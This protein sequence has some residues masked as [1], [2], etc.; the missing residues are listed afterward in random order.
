MWE[1]IVTFKCVLMFWPTMGVI[2]SL[3]A[4]L[5]I[6]NEQKAKYE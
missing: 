1:I 5:A 6:F 4:T 3:V 2:A